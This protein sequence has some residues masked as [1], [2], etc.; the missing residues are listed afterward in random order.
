VSPSASRSAP[1]ARI[2]AI[3]RNA[4]FTH[5]DSTPFEDQVAAVEDM[6]RPAVEGMSD[7]LRRRV[8]RGAERE[9]ATRIAASHWAYIA[10][11]GDEEAMRTREWI[12]R[13]TVTSENMA[14]VATELRGLKTV[15]AAP[16]TGSLGG[17]FHMTARELEATVAVRSLG[18]TA[19][20]PDA[21]LVD[22]PLRAA[23]L[24]FV[25]LMRS[26]GEPVL[27]RRGRSTPAPQALPQAQFDA[28]VSF[29]LEAADLRARVGQLVDD[30]AALRSEGRGDA[31]ETAADCL[32]TEREIL[33][34]LSRTRGLTNTAVDTV[35]GSLCF[36][37]GVPDPA[38][39]LIA[40]V[41]G[42]LVAD[43]KDQLVEQYCRK[44]LGSARMRIV[45]NADHLRRWEG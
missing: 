45:A 14:R 43:R 41:G 44:R 28:M 38:G 32:R 37:V 22:S 20:S 25:E 12:V 15:V 42:Y 24:E 39:L 10:L 27:G 34:E 31:I 26:E 18:L 4:L 16:I 29:L 6:F 21:V 11:F 36:L 3:R 23:V 1:L 35:A 5:I 33:R 9:G 30:F 40:A 7:K 13:G 17:A 19:K 8:F 2:Y